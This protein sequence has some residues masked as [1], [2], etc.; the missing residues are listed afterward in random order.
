MMDDTAVNELNKKHRNA[1]A[2]LR[3]TR[4][5]NALQLLI[6]GNRSVVEVRDLLLKVEL[7]L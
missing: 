1:K 4:Q 5:G 6:D 3:P 2:A 7:T